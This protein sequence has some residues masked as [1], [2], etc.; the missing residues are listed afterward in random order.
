MERI[1]TSLLPYLQYTVT[2]IFAKRRFGVRRCLE[3]DGPPDSCR[4]FGPARVCPVTCA[5]IARR[6]AECRNEGGYLRHLWTAGVELRRSDARSVTVLMFPS[7]AR[8]SA[9][10]AVEGQG[11]WVVWS[12]TRPP[13]TCTVHKARR[14]VPRRETGGG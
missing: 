11:G 2:S 14:S 4:E 6:R 7:P 13:H 12:Q 1:S 10:R 8:S 5:E 9:W 3:T